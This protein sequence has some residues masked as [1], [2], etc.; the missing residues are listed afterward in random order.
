MGACVGLILL[1]AERDGKIK[2]AT[3]NNKYTVRANAASKPDTRCFDTTLNTGLFV[4]GKAVD[5]FDNLINGYLS[6]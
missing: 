5:C 2:K 1:L 3:S 6:E 4:G